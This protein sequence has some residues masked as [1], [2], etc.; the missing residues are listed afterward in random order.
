MGEYI[1]ELELR[2]EWSFVKRSI[3]EEGGCWRLV[4][5]VFRCDLKCYFR[6]YDREK[7]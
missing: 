3:C 2:E 1:L 5:W 4:N 7:S 6:G